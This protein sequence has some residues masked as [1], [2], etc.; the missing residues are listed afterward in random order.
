MRS[1][2]VGGGGGG[3]DLE[4]V[5]R[6]DIKCRQYL[7]SMEKFSHVFSDPVFFTPVMMRW[8]L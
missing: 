2:E 3:V 8:R 5:P 6:P 4:E 7:S 1:A